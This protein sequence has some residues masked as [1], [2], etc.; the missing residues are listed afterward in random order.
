MIELFYLNAGKGE[1]LP[2]DKQFTLREFYNTYLK[3]SVKRDNRNF[4]TA[5]QNELSSNSL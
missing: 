5:Q 3:I 4:N 1:I 2:K